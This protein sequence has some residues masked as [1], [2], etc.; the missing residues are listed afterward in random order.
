MRFQFHA[1]IK[2]IEFIKIKTIKEI[3]KKIRILSMRMS[4]N[5]VHHL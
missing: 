3:N 5:E 2:Q 4:S 1:G